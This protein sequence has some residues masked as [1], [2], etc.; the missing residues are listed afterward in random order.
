M[1]Y[2]LLVLWIIVALSILREPR[3]GRVI[4]YLCIFSLLSSLAFFFLASP[5]TA[6]AEAAI[7]IFT[8]IFFIICFEKYEALKVDADPDAGHVPN[9]TRVVKLV[10]GPLVFTAALLGLVLWFLPD[11]VASGYIREQFLTQFRADVGGENAVTAIYL[12]YRVY[13]TL[14]EALVL[15]ITVVAVAHM[16]YSSAS[17]VTSGRE[18][19]V[20]HSLVEGSVLRIVSVVILLFGLYLIAN[21]HI[22][23][24]GGF[25]GGLF[26]AA[27]LI[28]RYL[29]YNI[30]DLPIARIFRLEE[31]IFASTV[32]VAAFV[33]F[34]GAST[35]VPTAFLPMFQSLYLIMMNFMI[36]MKV[37]LGFIILFYRYIAIERR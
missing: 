24:G 27:F 2:A 17:T 16:S 8:T 25:Q 26:I 35:F 28:C 12:G 29:I 15:V 14:F 11:H 20:K 37:A 31:V 18:S 32:L 21:G 30:Y 1:I 19:A 4:I 5:D 3:N 34:L 36:G 33:V 22:S 6:M 7:G 23:A 13:D 9:K 10:A